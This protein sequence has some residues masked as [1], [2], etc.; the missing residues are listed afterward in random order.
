M[1]ES[2]ASKTDQRRSRLL[3]DAVRAYGGTLLTRGAYVN[4]CDSTQDEARRLCNNAPGFVLWAGSQ[5]AGRGRLG[6]TWHEGIGLGIAMSF[7]LDAALGAERLS[8]IGAL[9]AHQACADCMLDTSVEV[10]LRWPNDVVERMG[11]GPGRKL[12]GVLVEVDRAN[13]LAILGIGVNVLQ[14][15]GHWPD[16]LRGKA[17]SLSDLGSSAD[18]ERVVRSIVRGV[19]SAASRDVAELAAA[20]TVIDT[21]AGT[22]QR[23]I[24]D[25]REYEGTVQSI[26]P[27]AA[28]RL[29]D[30][31]GV[32][33]TLPALTTSLVKD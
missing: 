8:L 7:V 25:G 9:G 13:G 33:H 2:V 10:G 26:D 27:A 22:H 30:S 1:R 6:R 18:H 24:H 4:T 32:E 29:L 12:A 21:L 28:I 3:G 5:T 20:F 23:F 19:V 14:Q 11:G 16:Q 15:A 31:Q 17:T